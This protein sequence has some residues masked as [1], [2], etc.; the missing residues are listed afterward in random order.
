MSIKI[1]IKN[2]QSSQTIARRD[3]DVSNV[4]I[5]F[6]DWYSRLY[7]LSISISAFK[8]FNRH[9]LD[10]PVGSGFVDEPA[11]CKAKINAIRFWRTI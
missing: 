4:Y 5:N 6:Y 9:R 1:W 10:S 2:H 7:S 3:D 11:W 8:R